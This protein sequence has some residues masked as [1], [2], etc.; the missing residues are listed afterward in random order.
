M[1]LSSSGEP[2]LG[3]AKR[4]ANSAAKG[5]AH[6]DTKRWTDIIVCGQHEAPGGQ[7]AF[8][9]LCQLYW[10]PLHA[11]VSRKGYSTHDAQDLIQDFF[12]HVLEN[13]AL[14]RV[15]SRGRASFQR[16]NFPVGHYSITAANYDPAEILPL[17]LPI[18]VYLN[19]GR[20]QRTV[21]IR[22]TM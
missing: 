15:V 16:I 18:H 14:V 9:R 21:T 20:R 22:V 10:V 5:A 2:L 3:R 1:D 6:F 7:S 4:D 8:A 13:G 11:F 17:G 19:E 12:L